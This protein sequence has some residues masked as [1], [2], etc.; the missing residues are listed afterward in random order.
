[1]ADNT[2]IYEGDYNNFIAYFPGYAKQY[3]IAAIYSLTVTIFDV[4]EKT[5]VTRSIA[6]YLYDNDCTIKFSLPF[7]DDFLPYKSYEISCT[8]TII[9]GSSKTTKEFVLN[10]DGG[11]DPIVSYSILASTE[12][13]TDIGGNEVIN[14]D[15]RTRVRAND[16]ILKSLYDDGWMDYKF[17]FGS[18]TEP[19]QDVLSVGELSSNNYSF[20]TRGFTCDFSNYKNLFKDKFSNDFRLALMHSGH[21]GF[22][23]IQTIAVSLG[24]VDTTPT[25]PT[26]NQVNNS[27]NTS[28]SSWLQAPSTGVPFISSIPELVSSIRT[29]ILT[30]PSGKYGASIDYYNF[31]IKDTLVGTCPYDSSVTA[32]PCTVPSVSVDTDTTFQISAVDTR[33]EES[34]RSNAKDLYIFAY[35]KPQITN[36]KVNRKNNFEKETTISCNAGYKRLNNLNT[37]TLKATCSAL[38]TGEKT[39]TTSIDKGS[40]NNTD[41]KLVEF[42]KIFSDS[43]YSDTSLY[44]KP[45]FDIEKSF[46]VTLTLTDRVGVAV[47][48][49]GFVPQG[50]PLFTQ[51]ETG[52]NAIGMIP[53][54]D[55]PCKL[56][57]NSDILAKDSDGNEIEI[58]NAIKNLIKL[59]T[60][61]NEPTQATGSYWIKATEIT[62]TIT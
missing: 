52:I 43:S 34:P 7:D 23:T 60:D 20:F 27:D 37:V 3:H 5:S 31:Y 40:D 4:T 22:V 12:A 13:D 59:T 36:I 15:V 42:Q 39:I 56:Q 46:N 51:T 21:S 50:V 41:Y 19:Y 58:I 16:S 47:A 29:D 61:E 53:K 8:V 11:F 14:L 1:M 33:G 32:I 25:A 38:W 55:S 10:L 6:D 54:W 26:I 2:I 30:Q 57:V 18:V 45:G 62:N 24:G 44:T 49:I 9:L 28:Y 48:T 17:V 35:E